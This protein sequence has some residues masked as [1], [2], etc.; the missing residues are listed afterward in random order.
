VR[1]STPAPGPGY[2]RYGGNTS[3]VVLT[4]DEDDPIALDAGTGL[5]V[6]GDSLSQTPSFRATA[7]VT[8]LHLD[9][10]QGLP[11]FTPLFRSGARMDIYGPEQIIGSLEKAMTRIFRPPLHPIRPSEIQG[12]IC[13]HEMTSD[14]MVIGNATVMVRPVPHL[15]PTVGY[16]VQHSGSS[17][18]YISDHHAPHDL[19]GVDR[20]VLELAADV[21]LLI[22]DAQYT[23]DDWAAKCDWGHCTVAYAVRVARMARARTL[24]LYHHDPYRDDDALDA[25]LAEARA[26]ASS[27]AGSLGP[28]Q[29]I[30]AREGMAIELKARSRAEFG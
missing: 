1:G 20:G 11:F 10:I 15:G 30:A 18:A 14:E 25:L 5:R 9:H 4:F 2:V 6:W 29:V 24:A 7:L 3:C 17:V 26:L 13:F 28:C 27:D 16:R 22:H 8:H 21:D 19:H 12:E 23:P